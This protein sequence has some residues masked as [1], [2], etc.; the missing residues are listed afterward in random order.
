MLMLIEEIRKME[1]QHAN[2]I[3]GVYLK[4]RDDVHKETILQELEGN[5]KYT[6]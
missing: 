4:V 6:H 3:Y 1:E 2:Y 5:F